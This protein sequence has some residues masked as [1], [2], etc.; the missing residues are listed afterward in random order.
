MSQLYDRLNHFVRISEKRLPQFD[1]QHK[2]RTARARKCI[3][4]YILLFPE[5]QTAE[6][7]E[8]SKKQG[9]LGN[10]AALDRGVL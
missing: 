5:G 8:P 2:V 6:A 4:I 1:S 9:S 3:F 7:S 10:R